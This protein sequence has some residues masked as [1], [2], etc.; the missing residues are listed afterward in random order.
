[1]L[2]R[3]DLEEMITAYNPIPTIRLSPSEQA[4]ADQLLRSLASEAPRVKEKKKRRVFV[5][6]SASIAVFVG[7]GGTAFAAGVTPTSVSMAIRAL[8]AADAGTVTYVDSVPADSSAS[9][10]L[11]VIAEA[12]RV[13]PD[14]GTPEQIAEVHY[15]GVSDGWFDSEPEPEVRKSDRWDWTFPDGISR[16]KTTTLGLDVPES[17]PESALEDLSDMDFFYQFTPPLPGNPNYDYTPRPTPAQM[18]LANDEVTM[19]DQMLWWSESEANSTFQ[20]VDAYLD[21]WSGGIGLTSSNRAAFLEF[22]AGREDVTYLGEATDSQGRVGEAF[23][24]SQN[25]DGISEEIRVIVDSET[26]MILATESIL[27]GPF[28]LGSY[29][30]VQNSN[31]FLEYRGI[32]SIAPCEEVV[33]CVVLPPEG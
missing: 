16:A 20:I 33:G 9:A 13:L 31:S 8:Q 32:D 30:H 18:V 10:K 29:D 14:L 15:I 6:V 27:H 11:A 2:K 26:G 4:R 21:L 24:V 3:N 19:V 28:I 17:Y 23:G 12:A 22:M 1:M 25:R 7:L 5:G